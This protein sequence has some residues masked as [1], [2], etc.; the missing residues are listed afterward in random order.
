MGT[1]LR[2]SFFFLFLWFW[3]SPDTKTRM[4]FFLVSVSVCGFTRWNTAW[5]IIRPGVWPLTWRW[6]SLEHSQWNIF[7][8]HSLTSG[9]WCGSDHTQKTM[10]KI[11]GASLKFNFEPY[12][13]GHFLGLLHFSFFLF[14]PY[15]TSQGQIA[16][17]TRRWY[18]RA[19]RWRSTSAQSATARTRRA[20]GRLSVRPP[21]VRTSASGARDWRLR[22]GGRRDTAGHAD[23]RPHESSWPFTQT[24]GHQGRTAAREYF[25]IYNH[26][27]ITERKSFY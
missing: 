12:H 1:T 18:Q 5:P 8:A 6:K 17:R 15:H 21:A 4:I 19:E 7:A 3:N 13:K 23:A 26:S 11:Y 25:R 24:T 27:W 20:R 16:T 22:V 14:L 9:T 10:S 2:N